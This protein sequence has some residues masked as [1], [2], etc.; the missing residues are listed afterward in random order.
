MTVCRMELLAWLAR[1]LVALDGPRVLVVIRAILGDGRFL[2]LVFLVFLPPNNLLRCAKRRTSIS[3]T[4]KS[5]AQGQHCVPGQRERRQW[6]TVRQCDS[7]A[8]EAAAQSMSPD[9]L[10]LQWCEQSV[11]SPLKGHT[12]ELSSFAW[13]NRAYFGPTCSTMES[14]ICCRDV[15]MNGK[16][17]KIVGC[18]RQGF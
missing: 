3:A 12:A 1:T 4:E 11:Y 2:L 15:V 16:Q 13:S 10:G 9:L 5:L 8:D 17:Q 18:K 14:R 6:A 7:S